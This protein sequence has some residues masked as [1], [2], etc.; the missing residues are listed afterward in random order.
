MFFSPLAKRAK[1]PD[2]CLAQRS[3]GI[4]YFRWNHRVYIAKYEAVTFQATQGLRQH[5]LR[6]TF[7]FPLNLAVPFCASSENADYQRCPFVGNEGE[8]LARGTV[9]VKDIVPVFGMIE[10]FQSKAPL[11]EACLLYNTR[12][13]PAASPLVPSCALGGM[14]PTFR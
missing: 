2:E 14:Y 13:A 4:L 10:Y 12:V 1:H 11:N 9:A 7:N 6:K 3:K 8:H 5:F